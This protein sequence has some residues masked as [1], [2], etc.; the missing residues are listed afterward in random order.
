[1]IL[2]K[3]ILAKESDKGCKVGQSRL[4]GLQLGGGVENWERRPAAHFRCGRSEMERLLHDDALVRRNE[5]GYG[6][7][8]TGAWFI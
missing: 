4:R 7:R 1:L 5:I 6:C 8:S 2:A 3:R